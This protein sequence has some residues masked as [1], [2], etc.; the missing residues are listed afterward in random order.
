MTAVALVLLAVL[1]VAPGSPARAG[2][3]RDGPRVRQP[4]RGS[5]RRGVQILA[6]LCSGLLCVLVGGPT[7][8]AL[9][10]LVVA[11]LAAAVVGRLHDRPERA[12]ADPRLPLVLDLAG[13]ALRAGQPVAAAVALA[14]P[15]AGPRVEAQLTQVA[16]LLRLGADAHEAW[17]PVVDGPLAPVAHAARRSA[18]SGAR[19][20]AGWEQL[21]VTLRA[22]RRA[23]AQARAQRAGV[24]VMAP[25]G[26]CF[27]PAFVCLGVIPV[28]AGIMRGV[29]GSW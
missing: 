18:T 1:I 20:A 16:G 4:A 2:R 12:A 17:Q 13:C 7:V 28:V 23:A 5:S 24:L 19:L 29:L 26:L 27:L 14:A 15:A 6:A 9:S 11:P 8:G 22:D 3:P 25:L 10:A 21:A